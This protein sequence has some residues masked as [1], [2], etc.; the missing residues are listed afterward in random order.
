MTCI[1]A[2]PA[3]DW[4][5]FQPIVCNWSSPPRRTGRLRNIASATGSSGTSTITTQFLAELDKVWQQC[6][7]V[8]LPGGRLICVVGDVCL[9]RRK[10]S[11]RH[12]VVPLHASIQE[13]CREIGF[14]NLAPIIWHKIANAVYEV[15]NGSR[16]PRQALRAERGHQ[17]RHRIHPDAAQARRLPQALRGHADPERHF[18][19]EPPAVVPADL[20]GRHRRLDQESSRPVTR[21]TLPNA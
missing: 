16:F 14:D 12:T 6:W 1:L 7:R 10:N 4:L 15:E 2:I 18:R 20:A 13:H 9:S 17:E 5:C 19:R 11:G 21:S 3:A 8:L